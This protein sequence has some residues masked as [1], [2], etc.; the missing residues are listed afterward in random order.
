MAL[1]FNDIEY[2]R[3]AEKLRQE[4]D[5]FSMK[6][7]PSTEWVEIFHRLN[8]YYVDFA[9]ITGMQKRKGLCLFFLKLS[10]ESYGFLLRKLAVIEM[11]IQVKRK[12]VDNPI[13]IEEKI[14]AI[15]AYAA[16]LERERGIVA[17]KLAE[18][19]AQGA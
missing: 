19:N 16:D 14:A 8:F 5:E 3:K 12:N 11:M 1:Y 4:I 6:Y 15:R 10:L 7:E 18:C 9:N 17:A 2:L 13:N